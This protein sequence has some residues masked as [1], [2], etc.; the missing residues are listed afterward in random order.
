MPGL[1]VEPSANEVSTIRVSGWDKEV[2]LKT[3]RSSLTH[4]LTRMV[5]TRSLSLPVLIPISGLP[6]VINFLPSLSA[7]LSL[8]KELR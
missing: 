7:P 4:P 2:P 6:V 3:Q 8:G 1:Q 5:L